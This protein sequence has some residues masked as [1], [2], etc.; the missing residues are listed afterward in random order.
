TVAGRVSPR[1]ASSRLTTHPCPGSETEAERRGSA[2]TSLL[3]EVSLLLRCSLLVVSD[4][5]EE[6]LH[7]GGTGLCTQARQRL[8][9]RPLCLEKLIQ[10]VDQCHV[11]PPLSK[12][13][14]HMTVVLAAE[15][16]HHV[17]RR[18][19]VFWVRSSS[20]R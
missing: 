15:V 11:H 14:Q 8:H 13:L 16:D 2:P 7:F 5:L 17:A 3:R 1:R 9:P 12:Q 19:R 6:L 18:M 20:G 4:L 10:P